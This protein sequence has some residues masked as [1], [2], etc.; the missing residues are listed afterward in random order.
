MKGYERIKKDIIEQYHKVN[1]RLENINKNTEY[2]VY[3]YYQ[4]ELERLESILYKIDVNIGIIK[5]NNDVSKHDK[6]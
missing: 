4:K 5:N 1:N 3:T 6:F 2:G